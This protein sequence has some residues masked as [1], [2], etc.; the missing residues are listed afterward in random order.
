MPLTYPDH[1]DVFEGA[2]PGFDSDWVRV[3]MLVAR[4]ESGLV[5]WPDSVDWTT[6]H[7]DGFKY[8]REVRARLEREFW[9][10]VEDP[11]QPITDTNAWYQDRVVAPLGH[12]TLF[13]VRLIEAE[14][15]RAD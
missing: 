5:P 13:L 14:E 4:S 6:D 8:L 9:Q 7:R 10:D 12:A 1:D 3:L 2:K 15:E 11:T